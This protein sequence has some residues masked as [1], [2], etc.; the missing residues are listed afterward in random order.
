LS[1]ASELRAKKAPSRVEAD[2]FIEAAVQADFVHQSIVVTFTMLFV[3]ACQPPPCPTAPVAG[4]PARAAG[5][6]IAPAAAQNPRPFTHSS[7]DLFAKLRLGWNLG[8]SLDVP[9]GETAWGNPAATPELMRAVAAAGFQLVRIPVTWTQR[10]GPAPDFAIE[11]AF[12]ARVAEVVGY[13]HSA[14]LYCVINLHHD[15]ADNFKG[16]EWLTLNDADGKTT[17]ANNAVVRERFVKVWL[18]IA[19]YFSGYGEELLFESMN[20]IHDGYGNPDPRHFTF[21]NE[22]NQEFV[23]L[24]RASGGNNDKR[25]LI[26]PGYNTNI[27]HTIKGFELPTDPT[28]NR[29]S[30]SV[31]YYDPYLFALQAK[32]NTWGQASPGK[33]NWGQED[34]V[35]TQFDKL[36]TTY[37]DQGIGVFLGEYGATHQAD[38]ADY[39][40]YYVEYVTKAAV[41]RGIL[42]VYWDNGGQGSGGEK[43]GLIDRTKND[44]FHPNVMEALKRAATSS[45]SLADVQ[46]P[47]PSK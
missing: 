45:Y 10:T 44:V 17:D 18:Q 20:E 38:Y 13:A 35:V 26:V 8:N 6:A 16:A 9:E 34:F 41:D 42:P 14:G 28:P 22:L 11:P 7:K 15:G 47:K 39:Q 23:K 32:T 43:F 2:W 46:P 19:R 4:G 36:K 40:R 3:G 31:H 37:I 29:V 33:D 1:R 27:D 24:V 12:L 21:I 30:V 5:S 25:H